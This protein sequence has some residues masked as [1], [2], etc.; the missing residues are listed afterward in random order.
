VGQSLRAQ[1]SDTARTYVWTSPGSADVAAYYAVTP[2]EVRRVD[3]SG[4]LAGG[5]SVVPGYLLARLALDQS[6]HGTGLGTWL[7]I[8]ALEIMLN[9]AEVAGGRI[10]VDVIDESAAKF[11]ARHGFQPIKHNP[12]RLVMKMASCRAILEQTAPKPN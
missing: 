2:T 1:R 8:D 5:V 7:L 4:S 12:L 10:V 9:A 6:L 11:Y 3:L